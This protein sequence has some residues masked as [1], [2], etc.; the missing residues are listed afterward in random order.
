MKGKR[1]H[2]YLFGHACPLGSLKGEI[3]FNQSKNLAFALEAL[4]FKEF[5]IFSKLG[6][7][8]ID[9]RAGESACQK[10]N[11]Q[12]DSYNIESFFKSP[13]GIV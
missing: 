12:N 5:Q 4:F 2:W 11:S 9:K 7:L 1:L 3:L 6:I 13:L 8:G 10:Y